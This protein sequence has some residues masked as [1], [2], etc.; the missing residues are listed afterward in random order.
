[1]DT[2]T[3]EVLA[4]ALIIVAGIVAYFEIALSSPTSLPPSQDVTSEREPEDFITIL[5]LPP[6]TDVQSAVKV[7]VPGQ[8][9]KTKGK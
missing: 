5:E 7:G 2:T 3:W 9:K 8:I 1:M 4:T 6:V